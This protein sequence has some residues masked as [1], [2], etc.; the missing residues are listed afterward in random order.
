M[1]TVTSPR[2]IHPLV[3]TAA[4]A[5]TVVS[6]VGVAAITGLLPTSH[7]E[8][9]PQITTS[10]P[11]AATPQQQVNNLAQ[12][13]PSTSY[14]TPLQTPQNTPV[15]SAVATRCSNCG[16]VEAIRTVQHTPQASGVGIVAGALLGGILGHQVGAGNGRTLATV[17]GAGAGG[18]AGNEVEKHSR[19]TTTYV[20]EVRMENGKL[21]S[22]PRNTDDW[23]VGDQVR[24]VNGQLRSLG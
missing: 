11:A 20:I 6:L 13:A 22:F 5:L 23:H 8:V 4:V 9:S 10:N 24:V 7:G 3:G 15:P 17:A 18:Y 2:R 19:T 21:R 12:T 1:D 16:Q 14:S